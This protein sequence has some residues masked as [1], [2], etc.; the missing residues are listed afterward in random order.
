MSGRDI[1]RRSGSE[2]RQMSLAAYWHGSLNPRRRGGRRASDLNYPIV[3]WHSARVLALV[4][5]ILYSALTII[6]IVLGIGG[7]LVVS[8]MMQ[9][10]LFEVAPADPAVYLALSAGLLLVTECASWFPAR[11]ATR[12]DPV[13]ALRTE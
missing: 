8:K 5:T 11:R 10:M 2:R 4:I 9:Q 3:D 7:A 1:E 13:I 12:I 6:G